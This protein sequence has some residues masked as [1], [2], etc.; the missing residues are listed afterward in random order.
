MQ[1]LLHA[2]THIIGFEAGLGRLEAQVSELQQVCTLCMQDSCASCTRWTSC[3][4]CTSCRL[5]ERCR[6]DRRSRGT[7]CG[8]YSGGSGR[9]NRGLLPEDGLR[10][11]LRE[12]P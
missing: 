11:A 4:F 12:A 9:G 10:C 1:M 3:W 5:L 7:G 8:V 6:L 2:L